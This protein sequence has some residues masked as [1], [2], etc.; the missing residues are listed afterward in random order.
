[1]PITFDTH[2]LITRLTQGQMSLEQAEAVSDALQEAVE[3]SIGQLATKSDIADLRTEL[4]H[5]KW[6][7][8]VN[9]TLVV[10]I[11][12]KLLLFMKP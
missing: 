6:M 7:I 2:K 12:G 11:L 8:G 1:M 5:V 9:M 4:K 3:G 10:L